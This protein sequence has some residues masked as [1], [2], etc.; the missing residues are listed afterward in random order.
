MITALFA[1]AALGVGLVA[2]GWLG[3]G[4]G[5]HEGIE[6]AQFRRSG[7]SNHYWEPCREAPWVAR[8]GP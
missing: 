7:E 4:A 2:G 6:D 5:Y 8:A 3:F 1:F